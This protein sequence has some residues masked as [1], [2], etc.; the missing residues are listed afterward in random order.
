PATPP[1]PAPQTGFTDSDGNPATL[2]DFKGKPTLVNL[3]ATWCQPCLKEMPSLQ[4]LQAKLA[5]RL[6]IAAVSQDRAGGKLVNPFVAEQNLQ[7]LKIYLD[8]KGDV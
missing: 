4:R 8:P 3:W 5:G 7:D 6:T 1:Q 2:S